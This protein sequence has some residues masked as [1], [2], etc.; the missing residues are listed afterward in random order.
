MPKYFTADV[1]RK[2]GISKSTLLRWLRT[3]EIPEPERQQM[4]GIEVRVWS[5]RDV[6]RL[7][8]Y[9]E[10]HYNEGKGRGPRPNARKEQ[11]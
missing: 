10:E 9:K 2:A 8:K 5:E 7:I 11:K 3:E 4:G 6:A 1:A